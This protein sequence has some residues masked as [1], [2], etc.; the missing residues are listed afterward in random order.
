MKAQHVNVWDAPKAEF[1][2]TSVASNVSII[3]KKSKG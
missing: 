1:K 3:K 2:R